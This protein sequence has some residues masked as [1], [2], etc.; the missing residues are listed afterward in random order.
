MAFSMFSIDFYNN[1]LYKIVNKEVFDL[2]SQVQTTK[3]W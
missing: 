3:N 2:I 1:D